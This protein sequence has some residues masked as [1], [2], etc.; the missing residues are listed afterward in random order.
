ME[1][2]SSEPER[3]PRTAWDRWVDARMWRWALILVL[4]L[5]GI[6]FAMFDE[7]LKVYEDQLAQT[8]DNA[9]VEVCRPLSVTDPGVIGYLLLILVLLWPDI[10]QVSI[11]VLSLTQKVD[12]QTERTEKLRS[13][14]AGLR[15]ASSQQVSVLSHQVSN[16]SQE[17]VSRVSQD[18]SSQLRAA[19]AQFFSPSNTFAPQIVLPSLDASLSAALAQRP[20]QTVAIPSGI[21]VTELLAPIRDQ[22]AY[23][24]IGLPEAWRALDGRKLEGV[25]VAVVGSG[26]DAGLQDVEGIGSQLESPYVT[27]GTV[28]GAFV[29]IGN[30][31]VG[32]VLAI[33]PSALISPVEVPVAGAGLASPRAFEEGIVAAVS[34]GAQVL[35]LGFGGGEPIPEV[36]ARLA[37]QG[38]E[39]LIVAPEGNG[40]AST[41]IW[42]ASAEGVV[43][44]AAVTG[45]GE[46]APFSNYGAR[47]DMAAPGIDVDSLAGLAPSGELLFRPLSGTS[48]SADILA[49]IGALLLST[50]KLGPSAILDL[51]R[52]TAAPSTAE[53]LPIVDAAAAV[54]S[55]VGGE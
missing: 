30:A 45:T 8:G 48:V 14:V 53:G 44:V 18:M 21:S 37:E 5:Y 15:T 33:A 36:E 4:V 52:K 49:G 1:T 6:A 16:A 11:G 55:V 10:S 29:E 24:K 46:R 39:I 23:A 43:S 9:V 12:K 22:Q 42:P 47:V 35:L 20:S 40:A 54:R 31:S 3:K 19:Q 50:G 13:E 17:M 41:S 27:R 25:R 51:L 7:H 28:P 32:H 26:T 2:E 34:R 38:R